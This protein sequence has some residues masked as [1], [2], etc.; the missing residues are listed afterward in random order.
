MPRQNLASSL[1]C[2][3]DL[4]HRQRLQLGGEHLHPG[5]PGYVGDSLSVP[6]LAFPPVVVAEMPR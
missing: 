1:T 3:G 6:E 2:R 5:D 4:G